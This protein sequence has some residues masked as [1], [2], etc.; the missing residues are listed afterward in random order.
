MNMHLA[1]DIMTVLSKV[2]FELDEQG[3]PNF[4]FKVTEAVFHPQY[5]LKNK[6]YYL[7]FLI[8]FGFGIHSKTLLPPSCTTVEMDT[9]VT[10]KHYSMHHSLLIRMTFRFNCC[11]KI[12][13]I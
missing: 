12:I 5:L 4:K 7:Q 8:I 6:S 11:S 13:E 3:G 1:F 10:D 2:K 9:D